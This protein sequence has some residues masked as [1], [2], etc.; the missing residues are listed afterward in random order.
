MKAWLIFFLPLIVTPGAYSG[1]TGGVPSESVPK[2][3]PLIWVD[4]IFGG[5]TNTAWNQSNL[6]YITFIT[7]DGARYDFTVRE[8]GREY[9]CRRVW[10]AM[11]N[12]NRRDLSH[13]EMRGLRAALAEFPTNSASPPLGRTVLV[14]FRSG[15][16]WATRICDYTQQPAELRRIFQ[17]IGEREE[18]KR[19]PQSQSGVP[20]HSIQRMEASRSGQLEFV[21]QRRL[22]STA[23]AERYCG[24]T[25]PAP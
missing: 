10:Y 20:N 9:D 8:D 24:L 23:D 19:K 6:L 15:S 18:L 7:D 3:Q 4:D 13:Q 25:T 11:H 17:L 14:S 5:H 21:C 1:D 22:A 12:S 16:N 2:R